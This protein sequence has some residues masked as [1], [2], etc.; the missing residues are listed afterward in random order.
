MRRE[1]PVFWVS[2]KDL[3]AEASD[4]IVNDK[5]GVSSEY[6]RTVPFVGHLVSSFTPIVCSA[7]MARV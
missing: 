7:A 3:L 5:V 4:D 1:S 6:S 2:A